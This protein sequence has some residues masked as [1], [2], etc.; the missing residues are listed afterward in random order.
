M[1]GKKGLGVTK[2]IICDD[3]TLKDMKDSR[4]QKK[5]I[6]RGDNRR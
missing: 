3:W 6:L 1:R 4:K 2:K 5:I